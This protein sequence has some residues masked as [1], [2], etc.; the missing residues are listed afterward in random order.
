MQELSVTLIGDSIAK[1]I[2]TKN[3]K[4]EKIKNCASSLIEKF[5]GYKFNNISVY[6]QTIKRIN[7]KRLI[8]DYI[9]NID[10][11][12]R[13]IVVFS[14]GGNDSDF[15]WKAVAENPL[16]KHNPKTS[17]DEFVSLLDMLIKKLKEN[18]VEVY[19]TGLPPINSELY[20]KNVIC[21]I[22]DG[23]EV[24][25]FFNGDITNIQRHQE[26]Y[27][28]LV[29]KTAIKNNCRFLDVRSYFLAKRDYLSSF[30]IDGVH[31]NELGHYEIANEIKKQLISYGIKPNPSLKDEII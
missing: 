9:S 19:L 28:F 2:A 10:K 30:C 25:K 18:N 14:I 13:N 27:N 3:F 16:I 20:F 8:Q 22:A 12:K 4:L 29:Y 31:P 24:L 17:A 15:D 1:G 26:L 5:L 11:S 23:N 6:G 21:K 7:D